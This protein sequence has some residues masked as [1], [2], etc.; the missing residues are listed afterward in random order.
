MA[1]KRKASAMLHKVFK[2]KYYF[3]LKNSI[4]IHCWP[5]KWLVIAKNRRCWLG[6]LEWNK[7]KILSFLVVMDER[8]VC[9]C[10][11]ILIS[12][13]IFCS[14][15]SSSSF[16]LLLLLC[17]LGIYVIKTMCSEM[18]DV[19]ML[20]EVL[21]KNRNPETRKWVWKRKRKRKEKHCSSG[22]TTTEEPIDQ[23]YRDP[24]ILNMLLSGNIGARG[25]W[26]GWAERSV[27]CCY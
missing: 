20:A 11:A 7:S 19:S 3:T 9:L 21:Q 16:W 6:R 23:N 15:S 2:R 18:D 1:A 26:D 13:H 25:V 22:S 14:S 8:S 24:N 17:L 5:M 10:C 27:V 4:A 12:F